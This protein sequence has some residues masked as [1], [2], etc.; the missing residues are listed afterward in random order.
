[1]IRHAREFSAVDGELLVRMRGVQPASLGHYLTGGIVDPVIRSLT[2]ARFLGRAVTVRQ[3]LPDGVP[4]HRV[5]D[6]LCT[7]DVLVIDRVGDHRI[8]CV[9]EMVARAAHARGAAGIVVDGVVTDIEELREIGMP[10]HARGTSVAT[11]RK[12]DLPGA[13]LFGQVTIGGV[14]IRQGDIIFGDANGVLC[15][16][17][18]DPDLS[19]IVDRAVADEIR[20][21]DWRIR[22]AGGDSLAELNGVKPS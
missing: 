8:A 7:G 4:V 5:L 6:E 12:L 2:G 22:L 11:T 18:R 15:L 17:P 14:V 19:D 20:E 16:D 10:I 1:M 21:V 9:G 3:P 13:E